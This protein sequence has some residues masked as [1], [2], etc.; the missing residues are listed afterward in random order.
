MQSMM[1]AILVAMLATVGLSDEAAAGPAPVT[2]NFDA[3][4]AEH[5]STGPSNF[6]QYNGPF[7]LVDVVV[8]WSGSASSGYSF[9]VGNPNPTPF[10]V[11]YSGLVGFVIYE[12]GDSASL[13]LSGTSI[14]TDLDCQVGIAGSG[15]AHFNPAAY[16]GAGLLTIDS[17]SFINPHW[18]SFQ[19]GGFSYEATGTVT[20]VL[21]VPEPASWAML[22]SGFGLIGGALRAHRKGLVAQ[23]AAFATLKR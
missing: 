9:P 10:P 1:R 6:P 16:I 20:Y 17:Q 14:C 13:S 4:Y 5:G 3:R 12:T 7:T 23:T 18:D 15:V 11:A 21:G 8:N 2:Y 19:S 22:L